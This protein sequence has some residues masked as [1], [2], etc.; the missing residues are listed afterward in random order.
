MPAMAEFC[1][2]QKGECF[3]RCTGNSECLSFGIGDVNECPRELQCRLYSQVIVDE[4]YF[5]KSRRYSYYIMVSNNILV[6]DWSKR[7]G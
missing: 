7:V 3:I 4:D 1:V 2:K 6:R 5:I